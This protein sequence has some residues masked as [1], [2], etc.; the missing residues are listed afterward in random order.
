MIYHIIEETELLPP[1]KSRQMEVTLELM[2]ITLSARIIPQLL[3]TQATITTTDPV[4]WEFSFWTPGPCAAPQQ[5][6][7]PLCFIPLITF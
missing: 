1:R 5:S 7:S 3:T 2:L 4:C 6:P